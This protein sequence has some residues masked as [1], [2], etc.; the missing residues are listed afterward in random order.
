MKKIDV[1]PGDIYG[2]LE[3]VEEVAT[4]GKR[5]VICR[6]SCG[7]CVEVRLGHLRSGRTKSC[8]KCGLEWRGERKTLRRWA[9]E[10]NIKPSTLRARLKKMELGEALEKGSGK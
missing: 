4:S 6:C 1:Q 10:Y 5:R 3:V 7:V 2:E 9:E 8:G